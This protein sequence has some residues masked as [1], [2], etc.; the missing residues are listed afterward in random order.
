MRKSFYLQ[1]QT[2]LTLLYLPTILLALYF[3]DSKIY[4]YRKS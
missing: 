3:L 2:K 4:V 1:M